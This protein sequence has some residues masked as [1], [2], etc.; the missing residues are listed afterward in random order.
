M[1]APL[2]GGRDEKSIFLKEDWVCSWKRWEVPSLVKRREEKGK[3]SALA[4]TIP[5]FLPWLC[6]FFLFQII[7]NKRTPPSLSRHSSEP[8]PSLPPP[9]KIGFFLA[10]YRLLHDPSPLLLPCCCSVCDVYGRPS[11]FPCCNAC[12]CW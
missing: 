4:A 11:S 3:P 1:F 10:F 2:R 12:F 7:P 6:S 5:L 8:L 9:K